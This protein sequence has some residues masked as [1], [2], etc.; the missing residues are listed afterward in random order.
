MNFFTEHGILSKNI[1][2][3]LLKR[4]T[5]IRFTQPFWQRIFGLSTIWVTTTDV[6]SEVLPIYGITNGRQV[7]QQLREAVA[8]ER[9]NVQE[10]EIRRV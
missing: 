4:V 6:T 5:D 8:E 1:D 10:R 9:K 3:I 7:W 2:E